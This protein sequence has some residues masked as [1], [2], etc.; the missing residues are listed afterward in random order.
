[1]ELKNRIAMSPMCMYSCL[2]RDGQVTDWHKIH[3]PTRAVG[4][5]A[6]IM[7]EA[8]AVTEQGRISTEDLGIW[9]DGHI[10]GLRELVR[11]VHGQGAKIGIQLAH[12]GRKARLDGPIV[13][14]SA[15]PFPGMKTPEAMSPAQIR[16]T[17]D[18]FAA[19]AERAKA[20]G[21]DCIEIHAAHGYLINQF[22]SPLANRREDEYGGT[23]DN[24][25]RFLKE[26]IAAV[27]SVWPGP[28]FVRI[29][30]EEYDPDGNHIEDYVRFAN[31][32]K[33]DGVDLID[34]SSG[35]V[36]P[37]E[38]KLFPGYQV[39][40]A[41]RIRHAVGIPTGAV[42]LITDPSHAEEILQQGRADLIFLGRELLRDPYWPRRAARELGFEIAGPRQYQRGW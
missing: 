4:Q 17:V 14:P 25:Y 27:R 28:M 29:S 30:A 33:A 39:P 5:V 9:S 1:M 31:W 19:A 12:A 42:G 34:C 22:L 21:F 13:A 18:A 7:V 6:L 32:M 40:Y 26:I 41:E 8:T 16:Q 24:R 38:I 2:A 10:E 37:A 20:A 35:S 3:Y 23:P 11:L 36:V 15:I